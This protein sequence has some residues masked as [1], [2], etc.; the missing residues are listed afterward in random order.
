MFG[1]IPRKECSNLHVCSEQE[2]REGSLVRRRYLWDVALQCRG[3]GFLK[4]S[5]RRR[6]YYS[7]GEFVRAPSL[8][9]FP[10]TNGICGRE[11]VDQ[12]PFVR[13]PGLR[14]LHCVGGL[15]VGMLVEDITVTGD[16]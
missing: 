7:G 5:A 8:V 11:E 1:I 10:G 4:G 13:R 2:A 9:P 15:S 14:G 16:I 12:A 6:S 3:A